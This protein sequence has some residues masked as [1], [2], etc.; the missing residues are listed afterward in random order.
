MIDVLNHIDD[1]KKIRNKIISDDVQ[2][3]LKLVDEC[4]AYKEKEVA[5][6]EKWAEKEGQMEP[7]NSVEQMELFV[8]KG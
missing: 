5:E 7:V 1:L 3:A 6:F 4:I 8:S 2:G